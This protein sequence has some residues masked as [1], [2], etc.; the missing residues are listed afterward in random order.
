VPAGLSRFAVV[1]TGASAA[2]RYR[3]SRPKAR[4]SLPA[5]FCAPP[6]AE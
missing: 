3:S 5:P 1:V 6:S 2:P 4:S